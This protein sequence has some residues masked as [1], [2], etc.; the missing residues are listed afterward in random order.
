HVHADR[1]FV[2]WSSL[3][4]PMRLVLSGI[5]VTNDVDQVVATAPSVALSFE[6]RSV[7]TGHLLPTA[8]VVS[9]PTLDADVAREGGMLRQVLAKTDS[10]SDGGEV[11]NLLID[12]LLA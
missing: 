8:I 7:I 3:S 1:I 4:Q 10:N 9:Q 11:V 6:P 2:E 5:K 12:Q